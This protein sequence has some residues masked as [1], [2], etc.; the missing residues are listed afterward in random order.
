MSTLSSVMNSALKSM[1]ANQLALSVASNNI[2][3]AGNL[4]YTRQRLILAPSDS[5]ENTHGIGRGVDVLGVAAIRDS[6]IEARI[7]QEISAKSGD[8]ALANRL[9]SMEVL[10]NDSAN[11]GLLQ[12][13]TTFFNGFHDLSLDPASTN[14]REQLK[15]SA[16]SLA[17]AFHTR[18]RDLK[19]IQNAANQSISS[20]VDRINVLASQIANVSEQ[21]KVNEISHP[22]HEL[23]DRRNALVKELSEMVEVHELESD[24]DYQLT[25]KDNRLLVLNG[26][27]QTLTTADVTSSIGNGSLKADVEIRDQYVPKYLAA[28][29]Q[30]AYELSAQVN[31]IHSAAYNLDGGTNVDFF[32]PLGSAADAAGL[33][34]LSS[35]I[36]ADVRKIA[37]SELP[38]GNDNGAAMKL[39]NLLHAPV[40]T[41]GSITDQYRSIVFNIGTDVAVTSSNFAAHEDIATQLENRRQSL[42]GVSID[43]ETVQILQ[44]QRAY[45]ASAQLIRAVDEMLQI[46]LRMT[47]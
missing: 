1:T 13:L 24:G 5:R 25:T 45:E 32:E 18:S 17:N 11:T 35:I 38:T 15:I 39:G 36:A 46:T 8:G 34:N 28:L 44:F 19:N 12:T 37:A 27:T 14:Y 40:F 31:A 20:Q 9:G 29:D 2:A 4:N 30:L 7:K 41:G 21:I 3:N 33:I 42:S 16:Q 43:E 47:G 6:L 23:R 10:F 26:V 22:A